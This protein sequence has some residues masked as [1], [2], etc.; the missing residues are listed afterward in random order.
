MIELTTVLVAFT[1]KSVRH[2]KSN[3]STLE[4]QVTVHKPDLFPIISAPAESTH[5]TALG[6][7]MMLMVSRFLIVSLGRHF[8][9]SSSYLT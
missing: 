5:T 4:S 8:I 1:P 2:K 6:H 7:A 9:T 3:V